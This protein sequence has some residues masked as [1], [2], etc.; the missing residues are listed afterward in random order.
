MDLQEQKATEIDWGLKPLHDKMLEIMQYIHDF[1]VEN[2]IEYCL[3][4]G[5]V[6][7]AVR[8][9]GF[10]PWD[11]D[12][13]IYMTAEGYK[14]F[15]ELFKAKG[16]HKNFFLQ[17]LDETDGM[18]ELPK[19]RMNGTTFIEPLYAKYNMHHGIYVDIFIL[20]KAPR[21]YFKKKKM[22]Y[23]LQ[24]L[25]LKKLAEIH[26]DRRRVY[27]PILALLRCLPKN[28]LRKSA[29]RMLYK[30]DVDNT[31][32][33][34]STGEIYAKRAFIQSEIIFPTK[35]MKFEDKEF[36][37]PGETDAYLKLMYGDY[38]QIPSLESIKWTQHAAVWDVN[39]DYRD[40]IK[41]FE[42]K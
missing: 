36:Y 5:S 41:N 9:G 30:Y 23:A 32:S 7:G 17:E 31:I 16:D 13:D 8:H 42:S 20:H 26:Y 35:R 14:R 21:S 18:C 15:K 12:M 2:H 10:I 25:T 4:F 3:A 19:L 29:L 11:D 1:C 40:Y 37:V 24:Y 33:E 34:Y 27:K 39:V 28:F 38:M 6:L 22:L